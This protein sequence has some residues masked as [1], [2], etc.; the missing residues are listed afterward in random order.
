MK[1]LT[2]LINVKITD[3]RN[4]SFYHRSP[5]VKRDNRGEV[6]KYSL[7][8]Y[9]SFDSL[10]DKY[11]FFIELENNYIERK[12]E[13]ENFIFSIFPKEKINLNWYRHSTRDQ[14]KSFCDNKINDEDIILTLCNDDHVF[15]DY[16]LDMIQSSIKILEE[17]IDPYSVV[18]IS[19]WPEQ[20]LLSFYKNAQLTEDKNFFKFEWNN[21]DAIQI[22]KGSR[23]K[24]YWEN[25]WGNIPL[26]KTDYLIFQNYQLPSNFYSP[27][28]EM[29]RHYDGY[30]H[31]GHVGSLENFC[32]PLYI[33]KGFFERQIKIKFGFDQYFE[34]CVN[35]N[36]TVPNI[37]SADSQ[38]SADYRWVKEDIPL[39]WK[40]RISA[41][42]FSEN[43]D[44]K[45]QRKFRNDYFFSCTKLNLN[46]LKLF[47]LFWSTD[48]LSHIDNR[49][50]DNFSNHIR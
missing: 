9:S 36:A 46:K 31:V 37:F 45:E 4:E 2:V 13:F 25:D 47:D 22:I 8:S 39:F 14:W 5:W 40:P 1:K 20:M 42:E 27:T 33:P 48:V 19:H 30:G 38:S 11:H 21:F 23:L 24:K 10:V 32:P 15:I 7:D 26:F 44:E 28:R 18:Y 43:Y 6:F 41:I 49:T 29:F 3:E 34:D 16:N 12:D 17:D 50:I 35:I